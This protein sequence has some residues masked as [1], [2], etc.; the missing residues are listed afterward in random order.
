LP[1]SLE[2]KLANGGLMNRV[3]CP[4]QV[5]DVAQTAR[6]KHR[7]EHAW[8]FGVRHDTT[9]PSPVEVQK[10]IRAIALPTKPF[11]QNCLPLH[12][13]GIKKPA[14]SF[15]GGYKQLVKNRVA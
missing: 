11:H 10:P 15:L 7:P 9:K 8:P 3:L 12:V 13:V 6:R 1:A 4:R 2:L 14:S 5:G